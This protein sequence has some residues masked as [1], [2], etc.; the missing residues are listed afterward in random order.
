MTTTDCCPHCKFDIPRT[1]L[2]CPHCAHDCRF[3]N[4]L[5]ASDTHERQVLA[6][7]YKVALEDAERRGCAIHVHEFDVKAKSTKAVIARSVIDVDRLA[8]TDKH[9]YS[10]YYQL[11][12]GGVRL[13]SGD[14]WDRLRRVT[15]ELL[16]GINAREIRFAALT[17]DGVGL[18]NYGACSMVLKEEMIAHCA[19]VFEENSVQFMH[20]HQIKVSDANALP[21]GHRCPWDARNQLCTAKLAADITPKTRTEDFPKLILSQGKTSED[22][23]FFEVHIFGPMTIRTFE[24]VVI[25]SRSKSRVRKSIREALRERL[26]ALP[27]RPDDAGVPLEIL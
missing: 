10:T 20:R 15:D 5:D 24:K 12:E 8:A 21:I 16:F 13:P 27:K 14:K 25:Q 4:V 3:P 18:D 17:L 6:D 1:E 2:R 11:L 9:L 26:E 19:S 7:R 23:V 22:D